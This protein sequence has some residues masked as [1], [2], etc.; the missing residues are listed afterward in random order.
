MAKGP[1]TDSSGR[2][3]VTVVKGDTLTQIAVDHA[4]GYSKYKQLAAINNIPNP[5]RIY[6]GQTIYL[7]KSSGSAAKKDSSDTTKAI[8]NQ[9]GIQSDDETG[10]TLFA[11]WT[12]DKEHT[13]SYKVSW[14]YDTGDGVWFNG[15]LSEITVDKDAP[16]LAKQSTYSIPTGAKRVRFKVKPISETY[17]KNNTDTNYW[18]AS[19]SETKTWTVTTPL[20]VPETPTVT[21]KKFKLTASLDNIDI[22]YATHIEFQVVKDDSVIVYASKKASIK[23]NHAAQVFDIVAGS[24]YK[25]RA[26]AYNNGTKEYS[27]W[28]EYS[29]NEGTIPGTPTS[30]IELYAK[31]STSVFIKWAGNNNATGY[32]IEYTTNMIYFDTSTEVSSVTIDSSEY[33]STSTIIPNLTTGTKY[34]F[35]VQATNEVGESGWTPIRSVSVGTKPAAPTTWSSTSTAITSE[36]VTLYWVHNSEDGSSQTYAELQL[37]IGDVLEEH[38]IKNTTDEE[39]KDKT[40]QWTLDTSSYSEGTS[41]KWRVRTKGII[42]EWS[43]WSVQRTITVNAPP[44]LQLNITRSNANYEISTLD[45]FPF[46]I[47]AIAGPT[48]QKPIGYHVTIVSNDIY[49]TVDRVGNPIIVNVGDEVYSKYFDTNEDLLLEM[50]AGNVDLENNAEYTVMC[51]VTMDSG[52]TADASA[53]FNVKWNEV[54]YVPNVEIGLDEDTMSV[55]I[56]PYCE[57]ATYVNYQVTYDPQNETYAKTT[58]ALWPL[59]WGERVGNDIYTLTGEAV[60]NGVTEDGEEVL[61]C[62]VTESELVDGVLLSVYRREFDGTFTELATDL[63]N[64]KPTTITDPHPALD[65]ARYRV[66]AIDVSTGGTTFYDPPP[67][68]VGGKAAIIQWDENWTSFEITEEDEM[69]QPAWSGSMLKLPYNIDVSESNS[70]DVSMIKYI[71]RTHPVTYYGTQLGVTAKWS[72]EVPKNDTETIY[73]LRRLSRWMG[74]VYVREPSG[75]GYWANIVVSFNQKHCETTVPV[76]LSISQVE[77]GI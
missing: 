70:S 67:Y 45:Y 27:D 20:G 13:A 71:G 44:T 7:T 24:V 10:N 60:W 8:I 23:T 30:I 53:V 73:A 5:D 14:T 26:R 51:T 43:D 76:T 21:I 1:Y 33:Y 4:G 50:T 35:R 39:E 63:D 52:L 47:R 54:H 15:S 40:S 6:I 38:T 61:F 56:R 37:Y 49:E 72:V 69:E 57:Q 68:P 42:D 64:L 29:K 12:W 58:T 48:T 32:T 65:F 16:E 31:S 77:G 55:S 46:Y 18:D 66:V 74:D 2:Q 9:F 19:W 17:K 62:N 59:W 11:T 28:S 41:V 3:Y 36:E 34:Y 25:V 22:D 75:S